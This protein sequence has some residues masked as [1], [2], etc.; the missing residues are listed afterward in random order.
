[1]HMRFWNVYLKLRIQ[2]AVGVSCLVGSGHSY[3]MAPVPHLP[4][5]PTTP[6]SANANTPTTYEN[7]GY[8]GLSWTFGVRSVLQMIFGLKSV[9]VDASNN[10]AGGEV[11]LAIP[12]ASPTDVTLKLKYLG[13]TTTAQGEAGIGYS[14]AQKSMLWNVGVGAPYAG[15]GLDY[16]PAS[17]LAPSLSINSLGPLR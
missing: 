7:R 1:M 2:A 17:G 9:S 8:A 11:M 10:V 15:A 4:A 3:A 13:G 5:A 12:M 6:I 14:L 16:L